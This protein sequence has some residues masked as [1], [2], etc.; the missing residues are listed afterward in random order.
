VSVTAAGPEPLGRAAQRRA[1]KPPE[2]SLWHYITVSLSTVL[3]ILVAA[4][5]ALVIVVPLVVGGQAL[6]V[7]TNSMAPDY[8]PG[9]LIVIGPTDPSDIAIGDV[10]T[11]QITSG[12]PAVISH[13]VVQRGVNLE[14]D[15]AFITKGDNND[16]VDPL[17]VTEAQIKGT[18]LYAIPQLGWVNNAVNGEARAWAGPVIAGSLFLYAGW[19]VVSAVRDRRG[20]RRTAQSAPTQP[21]SP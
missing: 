9:T 17:P 13:R 7:L 4:V 1:R 21:S 15:T 18:L 12:E 3:L 20:K 11:Y 10:L 6:T 16:V 2:K 19:S 5:A 14:G 8:P